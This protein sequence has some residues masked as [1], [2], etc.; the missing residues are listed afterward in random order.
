MKLAI[1]PTLLNSF[2]W[3]NNCP[4][5][6][7]QKAYDDIEATI[8]RWPKE[9]G[10]EAKKGAEFENAVQKIAEAGTVDT[11]KSSEEFKEVVRRC[12]GGKFQQWCD[13]YFQSGS[14]KV[15]AYG[16][17]DVQFPNLIIDIKTTK[18]FKGAH[19]Y[20]KGW[21]PTVYML[22]TGVETFEFVI[23]EWLAANSMKIATVHYAT[24][25]AEDGMEQSLI[26]H[27]EKFVGFLE[28]NKLYEAYLYDFCK[29][30]RPE[31]EE[32]V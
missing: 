3:Y 24:V 7:K 14:N 30:P 23:A 4:P 25:K 31:P 22:A 15:R 2:D 10:P 29:N 13:F 21:Q 9:F 16:K 6:W 5:D 1:T 19:S 11:V 27:Y 18:R 12:Q 32:A 8:R 28:K 20:T 17:I 26:A